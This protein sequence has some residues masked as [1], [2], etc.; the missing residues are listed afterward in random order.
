MTFQ[1]LIHTQSGVGGFSAAQ[2][3]FQ[4]CNLTVERYEAISLVRRKAVVRLKRSL[5]LASLTRAA[6]SLPVTVTHRV[7]ACCSDVEL[8]RYPE[9]WK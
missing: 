5:R 8:L 2:Q 9:F 6:I 1:C 7:C 4:R 3:I